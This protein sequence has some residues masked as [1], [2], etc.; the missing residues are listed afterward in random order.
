MGKAFF[1]TPQDVETAF[2]Q[3]LERCDLE[4][5]MAVWSEDDEIVCLHPGGPRLLGFA[6][7]RSAWQAIFS[8]GGR[9]KV[10]ISQVSR[11]QTPF[12]AIHSVIEHIG[13]ADQIARQTAPIAATNIYLRGPQGWRLLAHH[14]SVVPPQEDAAKPQVLH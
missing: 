7:I 1:A 3:A 12:T 4:A 8:G 5:M 11:V 2:Y 13:R 10:Q 14:A 6:Q 9:L